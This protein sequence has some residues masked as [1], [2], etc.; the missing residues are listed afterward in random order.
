[1]S[2]FQIFRI[3]VFPSQQLNFLEK[4]KGRADIL[5][6]VIQTKPSAKLRKEMIWHIGNV[7]KIGENGFYFRIGRIVE[8]KIEVLSEGDFVDQPL[9]TAPYTHVI[10]DPQL[11]IIAIAK[12]I[13]LSPT[14]SGIANQFIRLL[15]ESERAH[16][17]AA[18]F[19][20]SAITDPEDFI[21]HLKQA[22]AISRFWVR[23][24]KPNPFDVNQ[25]F[26]QPMQKLLKESSG[27][28]GKTELEGQNLNPQSLEE[29]ARSAASTG[30]DAGASIQMAEGQRKIRKRLKGNPIKISQQE[31]INQDEQKKNLLDQIRNIYQKNR[32]KLNIDD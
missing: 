32:G 25:D 14:I 24:S 12:K 11:E 9:K 22:Y 4:D 6:E 20:I 8:S 15:N 5:R 21:S 13:K 17:I 26:I 10:L 3:K 2:E 18:T 31:D 29:I 19:E 1:M 23:F 27:E 30:D 7:K 28:K 16:Q